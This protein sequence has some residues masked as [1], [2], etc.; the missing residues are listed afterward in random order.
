MRGTLL[1]D[2]DNAVGHG[3]IPAHAGNTGSK[4]AIMFN[5][6]DH[7]RAC[8]EHNS[9]MS[10]QLLGQGSSPRMRG[11]HTVM[12]T[13]LRTGGIIPAHAGNTIWRVRWSIL[14]RD[15]PRACGEHSSFSHACRMFSGSSPRMRGTHNQQARPQAQAGI[16]PAHAGNTVTYDGKD[17]EFRDHPRACGEHFCLFRLRS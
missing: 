15:H 5:R 7:P 6:G 17:E 13:R 14:A 12:R 1:G 8:G 11:T 3:I 10:G 2:G 9:Q 16:I 4:A